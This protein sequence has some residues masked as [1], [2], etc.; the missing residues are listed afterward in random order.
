MTLVRLAAERLGLLERYY[1]LGHGCGNLCLVDQSV[2]I[3]L[4]QEFQE[5]DICDILENG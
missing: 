4:L 1:A 2:A 3:A 5:Q